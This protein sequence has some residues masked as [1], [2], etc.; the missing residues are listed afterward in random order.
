MPI[1]LRQGLEQAAQYDDHKPP[2]LV[3][4]ERYQR[5]PF[6]IMRLVDFTDLFGPLQ[7]HE[8]EEEAA[9]VTEVQ[10]TAEEEAV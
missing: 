5:G 10:C 6:V 3:I 8:P 7:E 4:R 9:D 2:L 1:L